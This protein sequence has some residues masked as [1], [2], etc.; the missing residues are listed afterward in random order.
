[1]HLVDG[2]GAV[3]VHRTLAGLVS[4]KFLNS[5]GAEGLGFEAQCPAP[6][7]PSE[8]RPPLLPPLFFN[9]EAT[10]TADNNPYEGAEQK[11]H[12]RQCL[13][14]SP[15]DENEVPQTS[16]CSGFGEAGL[17]R[18]GGFPFAPNPAPQFV[19]APLETRWK[20]LTPDSLVF[21]LS[22]Q[23]VCDDR[24]GALSLPLQVFID[25]A[26][27]SLLVVGSGLKIQSPKFAQ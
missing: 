25:D 12:H 6:L 16:N 3:H 22:G 18:C 20:A 8:L 24:P 4:Y 27:N 1:L 7:P 10:D 17:K 5:L 11:S 2:D 26:L 21:F 19:C 14:R 9:L 23:V 13:T 15:P